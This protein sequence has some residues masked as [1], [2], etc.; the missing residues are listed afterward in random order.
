MRK[1]L[2]SEEQI[3]DVCQKIGKQLNEA[4]KNEERIPLLVGV[5]KGSIN[6]MMGLMRYIN[7]PFFTDYLQISSYVGTKRTNNVRLIKDL[8]YDVTD[9]TVIIVEDIIDTGYSMDFLINHLKIHHAKKILVCTLV[10]KACAR[11]VEVPIDFSGFVMHES[12]FIIGYGLDYNE[13]DRNVPYIYEA[14]QEE[15]ERLNDIL[16][17]DGEKI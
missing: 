12:K 9:R 14:D 16:K 8:S 3:N 15:V 4:L 7:V 1:V 10:D 6:F 17:K 11:E 13:L 5:M 2:F